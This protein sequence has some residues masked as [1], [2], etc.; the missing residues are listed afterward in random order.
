MKMGFVPEYRIE[1]AYN[2]IKK[3]IEE[4]KIKNYQDPKYNNHKLILN[5]KQFTSPELRAVLKH[6]FN[7]ICVQNQCTPRNAARRIALIIASSGTK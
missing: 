2:E 5:S 4:G 6:D 3:L 1:D 7:L